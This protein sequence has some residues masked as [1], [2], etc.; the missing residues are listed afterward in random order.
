MQTSLQHNWQLGFKYKYKTMKVLLF[1]I[2]VYRKY[3]SVLLLLAAGCMV[4]AQEQMLTVI[5]NTKGA[6]SEMKMSELRS[7]LRGEKQRWSN[8]TKVSI[9]LM[10]TSTP[11][12]QVTC[13][14]IY[15]MS[16]D[17]VKRFWL[18]LSFGGKSDAPTFCNSVAEL[19]S[20]VSQ[21]PGTIGILDKSSG[22]SNIKTIVIDGKHS[23]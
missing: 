16:G 12:G 10:K 2:A 8:G 20:Y 7:V 9:F 3:L 14:K 19:E 21:N 23:F 11:L 15:N 22:T 1:S 4:N 13:Q 5:S 6:P 18:E 17:K